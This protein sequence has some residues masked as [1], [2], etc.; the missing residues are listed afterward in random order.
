MTELKFEEL[1]QDDLRRIAEALERIADSM[2]GQRPQG[3]VSKM[4]EETWGVNPYG[5]KSD[6][7]PIEPPATGAPVDEG[8][9]CGAPAEANYSDHLESCPEWFPF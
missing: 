5:T 2:E 3:P 6:G 4:V 8:C 9:N 1:M 7:T